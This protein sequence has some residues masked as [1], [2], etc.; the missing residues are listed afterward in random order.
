MFVDEWLTVPTEILTA[1]EKVH[2]AWV[3][4]KAL[5]LCL[6]HIKA[7]DVNTKWICIGPVMRQ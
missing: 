7:E 3:R 6:D 4:K 2:S 1:Y 5:D